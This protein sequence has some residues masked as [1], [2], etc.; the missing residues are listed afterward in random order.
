M[1]PESRTAAQVHKVFISGLAEMSL[2][3]PAPMLFDI[4][5][6]APRQLYP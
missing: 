4:R 5:T 3:G 1:S 2:A 6:V